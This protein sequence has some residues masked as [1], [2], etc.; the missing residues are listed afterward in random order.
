MK[1]L[2]SKAQNAFQMHALGFRVS[3]KH[4]TCGIKN[5]VEGEML[6]NQPKAIV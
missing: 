6:E 1:K 2:A 5:F 3:E 4:E